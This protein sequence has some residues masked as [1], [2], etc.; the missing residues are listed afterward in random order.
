LLIG[1]AVQSAFKIFK[2]TAHEP[3]AAEEGTD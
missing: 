2:V 3:I 1:P